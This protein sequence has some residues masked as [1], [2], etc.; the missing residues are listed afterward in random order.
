MF[1]DVSAVDEHRRV[2]MGAADAQRHRLAAPGG[3][4][5]HG[6]PIPRGARVVVTQRAL[7]LADALRLPRAGHGDRARRRP[8]PPAGQPRRSPWSCGS[9]RNSHGPFRSMRARCA[10]HI[11]GTAQHEQGCEND[12]SHRA[13]GPRSESCCRVMFPCTS[14]GAPA[15]ARL[16]TR[17]AVVPISWNL[18]GR[19]QSRCRCGRRR[20]CSRCAAHAFSSVAATLCW[21]CRD[22]SCAAAG[23]A[24]ADAAT[25]DRAASRGGTRAAAQRTASE[26]RTARR[27]LVDH[28]VDA[29]RFESG[30]AAEGAA[31]RD[32]RRQGRRGRHRRSSS[33]IRRSRPRATQNVHVLWTD[34]IAASDADTARR[35][36]AIRR[37]AAAA[38]P[39][40]S[41][42]TPKARADSR[43]P[44]I[45]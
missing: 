15:A 17:C 32:A 21:P 30:D 11:G 12:G 38:G 1:A 8:R 27:G 6:A 4:N 25:S 2:A 26:R 44:S 3:R 7:R 43:S 31:S 19:H 10:W 14:R 33:S 24:T 5:G 29:A 45:S 36:C 18:A 9:C 35:L 37:S 40:R 23:S 39:D 34:L 41:S 16:R 13:I 20:P 28:S 42:S 22:Q